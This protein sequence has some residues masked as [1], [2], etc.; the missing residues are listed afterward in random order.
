[1]E[2]Q[3]I[4]NIKI[5]VDKNV[6]VPSES[7]STRFFIRHLPVLP[8]KTKTVLDLGCGSGALGI[9]YLKNK[10]K[11]N[12][13]FSDIK[14]NAINLTKK[15]LMLNKL[16]GNCIKSDLFKNIKKKFDVIIFNLPYSHITNNKNKN[17][18]DFKGKILKKF[19]YNFK[20]FLNKNGRVYITFSNLCNKQI[21]K[22]TKLKIIGKEIFIPSNET[23]MLLEVRL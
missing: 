17:K 7:S 16:K 15:N 6:Y 11:L 20:Y 2:L 13:T 22:N 23:R 14:S 19:L 3:Q 10:K 18:Y 21:L 12:I 8:N 1:M 5:I 4:G 9:Y